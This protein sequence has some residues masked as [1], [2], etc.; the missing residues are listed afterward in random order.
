M[1]NSVRHPH[2]LALES[3][4]CMGRRTGGT[5]KVYLQPT[6]GR[7]N[8]GVRSGEAHNVS[9]LAAT[10]RQKPLRSRLKKHLIDLITGHD[11]VMVVELDGAE[12][13]KYR[14]V[15]AFSLWEAPLKGQNGDGKHTL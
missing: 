1:R 7:D 5:G 13:T 10:E 8:I 11:I 6:S 14:K 3:Y 9:R 15:V 4:G 12:N 2:S